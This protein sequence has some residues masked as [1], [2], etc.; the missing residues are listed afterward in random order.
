MELSSHEYN[1]TVTSPYFFGIKELSNTEM[2]NLQKGQNLLLKRK[3]TSVGDGPSVYRRHY[4]VTMLLEAANLDRG[5]HFGELALIKTGKRRTATVITEED[6]HFAILDKKSYTRAMG[7]AVQDKLRERVEF[8]SQYKIFNGIN[9]SKLEN[10]T[11]FLH[12][13]EYQKG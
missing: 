2:K 6:T 4:N 11:Y 5:Y 12:K 1:E 8:L 9:A 10:L 7:K 3:G 13:Q